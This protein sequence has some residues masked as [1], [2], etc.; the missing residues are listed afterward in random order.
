MKRI[1]CINRII[2]IEIIGHIVYYDTVNTDEI[3][4]NGIYAI[5]VKYKNPNWL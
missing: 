3:I 5:R 1:K 2:C 4:K